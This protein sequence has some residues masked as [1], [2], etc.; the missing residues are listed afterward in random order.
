[1]TT[2]NEERRKK[3][4]EEDDDGEKTHLDARVRL[5]KNV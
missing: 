3:E 4:E 2:T 5:A 1:M